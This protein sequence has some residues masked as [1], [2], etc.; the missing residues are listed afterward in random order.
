MATIFTTKVSSKILELFTNIFNKKT[1]IPQNKDKDMVKNQWYAYIDDSTMESHNGQAVSR[2]I[3]QIAEMNVISEN[4]SPCVRTSNGDLIDKYLFNSMCRP[5][6]APVLELDTSEHID[7]S[8]FNQACKVVKDTPAP[9]VQNIQDSNTFENYNNVAKIT[10]GIQTPEPKPKIEY[11]NLFGQ[12]KCKEQN[13]DIKTAIM[14]PDIDLIKAMY[15]QS[16][17]E[18]KFLTDLAEYCIS[19]IS[20]DNIKES[21]LNIIIKQKKKSRS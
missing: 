2:D 20:I 13:I 16:N 1:S 15:E 12:W 9:V 4:G 14:M 5:I 21:M 10:E 8:A 6:P 7:F 19:A 11:Q 18:D 17:D 3:F